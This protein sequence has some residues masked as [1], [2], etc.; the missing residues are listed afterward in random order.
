MAL[1]RDV[2]NVGEEGGRRPLH[3]S[4]KEKPRWDA[5]KVVGSNSGRVHQRDAERLVMSFKVGVTQP[6]L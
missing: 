3:G 2:I 5:S 4:S 1:E 6:T